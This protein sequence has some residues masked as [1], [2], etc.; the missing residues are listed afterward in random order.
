LKSNKYLNRNRGKQA[1][2][3][4]WS[5]QKHCF[6]YV[7]LPLRNSLITLL[8][9]RVVNEQIPITMLFY[10]SD[11]EMLTTRWCSLGR[12]RPKGGRSLAANGEGGG[13]TGR[14]WG[15]A[16]TGSPRGP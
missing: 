15:T 7:L 8:S 10:Q 9:S 11:G 6:C 16:N 12:H 13:I 1:N 14:R 4:F 2:H 3:S 5:T